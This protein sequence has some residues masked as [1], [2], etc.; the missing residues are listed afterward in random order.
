VDPVPT[1][2]IVTAIRHDLQENAGTGAASVRN[3]R[4]K[5]SRT[6]KPENPERLL[7]AVTA[8]VRSGAWDDRLVGLELL[9]SHSGAFRKLND[10]LVEQLAD[11]LADWGSVD[12]FGVTIS[13]PAWREGLVSDTRI[14]AW[15]RSSDRWRRRLA[16][17]STVP[18]NSKARGGSGDARRTLLV[19]RQLKADRDDMVVKGVSWALRE[20]AKRHPTAVTQFMRDEGAELAPRIRR[21]V[22]N[23]LTTGLKAPRTRRRG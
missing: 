12:L 22:T 19:C 15:A 5:Y 11:G 2:S 13:G 10:E 1:A 23:K 8:L 7:A 4:R 20:L 14:S 18:L 9:L 3:V 6:L 17:V 21:E 16:L